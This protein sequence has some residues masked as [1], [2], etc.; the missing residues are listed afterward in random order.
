MVALSSVTLVSLLAGAAVTAGY[1]ATGAAPEPDSSDGGA[2]SA[3]ASADQYVTGKSTGFATSP[4]ETLTRQ[5]VVTTDQGLNYVSYSRTYRN[6][7]VFVGGDVVVVTDRAGK[8]RSST[9]GLVP[10][11][12][13]TDPKISEARARTL[14]LKGRPGA[15]A[16]KPSLGVVAAAGSK[17]V[18]EVVT[19]SRP[20]AAPSRAH[21]YVD[22]LTGANAGSWDEITAGT[23]TGFY[24]GTVPI[25]TASSGGSFQMRDT[26]RGNMRTF[27]DRTGQVFTDADDKWGGGSGSDLPTGAVDTQYAGSV[28]FD[29]LKAKFNRNGIDGQG[30]MAQMFVGLNDVNAFYSCA[31]TADASRDQSKYGKTQDGARQVNAIDVVAHELGHGVFCHTPGGSGG[32]SNETGGL[33][34][35]TG[36]IFGTL[37]EHFAA[38]PKDPTDFTV[39]EQVD[40]VG[41]GPI[42]NMADPSKAG[43]PN[44]FSSAIPGTEVHSAAGPLNHWFY[45]AAQGSA[46]ATGPASPTCDDSKVTGIGVWAAGE[47]FYHALLRKTS[48]WT[49]TKVRKATLEATKELHAGSCTE[50][51][52]VKAAW[53]AVSVPASGDPSC[54][55]SATPAPSASASAS[56]SAPSPSVS[57][58]TSTPPATPPAGV[59]DIDGA[60]VAAHLD[61]LNRI[62]TAN[63]G[64]RAHGKPGY[65]ASLDYVKAKLDAAGY[66]TRIQQFTS[67]GA[68]GYNLIADLPGRG[69][70]TKVVMLGAHLD[71]VAAGPGIDDNGTGSA[72]I[73]EVALTYARSGAAGDKGIR[74]GWWGAEELGLVGSKAY[75]ASLSTAER[76]KVTA[77][78]N[79]DMIGSPNAGYF[80]YNDDAKGSAISAALKA[81]FA[82]EK[83]ATENVDVQNRSDHASF[84]AAG[85]PTGGT[86]TLSLASA[87]SAAQAAKWGGTA[88]QPYD[89]CYHQACDVRTNVNATALDRHSDVAAYA[90][91]TLTG[92]KATPAASTRVENAADFLIRDRSA[93]ESPITVD[94]AGAAPSKLQVDVDIKHGYRGDLEIRLLAPDGTEFPIKKASRFDGGDDVKLT[95]TVDASAGQSTGTWRLRVRDLYSGDTGTLNAWGLTF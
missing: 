20:G 46:P 38:N 25:G 47:V 41:R 80:V 11:S 90:A 69:D 1:T 66:T 3:A 85:I 61:E 44:C 54:T 81:G 79:F 76:A 30:G 68:T 52:A 82:A 75:V 74:F 72:G 24:N 53:D 29:M 60:K 45:L 84:K 23:G 57:T 88:G 34:E 48:G 58:G 16:G 87:M 63:G 55:A 62:A 13:P 12:A 4:D 15:V 94:R 40:L 49:Y 83:I 77:Y 28:M 33:N 64:N 32:T 92:V 8:V 18:W 35:A 27:N 17:L 26:A 50:F 9:S 14:A 67:N 56:Q 86:A 6:L 51:N 70:P 89:P 37:A 93:I 78:L 43:D 39:G 31:G 7:P 91:W 36:D 95:A 19:E 22:A 73:L 65:Q 59:P 10:I 21:V 71:S 2:A 5:K 42:R